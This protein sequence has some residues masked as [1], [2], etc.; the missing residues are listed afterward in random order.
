MGIDDAAQEAV[1]KAKEGVGEAI[2]NEDLRQDGVKDRIEANAKQVAD[3]AKRR[4]GD[5]GSGLADTVESLK[6]KL[7]AKGD[8]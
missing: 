6:D 5:V 7:T 8:K 1:G 2:G 4:M 3:D